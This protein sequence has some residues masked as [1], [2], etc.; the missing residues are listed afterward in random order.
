MSHYGREY[1]DWQKE[2]GEFGGRENLF[3]FAGFIKPSDKVLEFGCGGGFLLSNISCAAKM[4]IEINPHARANAAKLGLTVVENASG[5]PDGWADVIISDNV[6]EHT[7]CPL[8]ELRKLRPKLRDGGRAVFVIPHELEMKYDPGDINQHLYT[9]NSLCAG[10]LF[11]TAGF[12]VEAITPIKY[13][14]PP[15][16]YGIRR[17]LGRFVFGLACGLY[18]RLLGRW[19]QLRVVAVKQA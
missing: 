12:S 3:K 18:C 14:W 2:M 11:K 1:F 17:Y 5:V 10:N 19:H 9:W 7:F 8:E 6:L 4:G 16:A 15:M 13:L